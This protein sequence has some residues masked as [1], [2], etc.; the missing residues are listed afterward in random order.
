MTNRYLE[1]HGHDARIDHRRHAERGLNEQPTIHEGVAARAMEKKGIISDRCELN[2]QIKADKRRL[3]FHVPKDDTK[4]SYGLI[5]YLYAGGFAA[6]DK[7][8][9]AKM[10]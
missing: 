4:E 2:R 9:D 10:L 5:V 6:G 3:A 8:D 7:T 1:Q